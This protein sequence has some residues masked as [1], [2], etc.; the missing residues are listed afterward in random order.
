MTFQICFLFATAMKG[1][2][3][4]GPVSVSC[5]CKMKRN[6]SKKGSSGNRAFVDSKFLYTEG[7]FFNFLVL[8]TYFTI[9][10]IKGFSF[11][12][13]QNASLSYRPHTE[14]L[15]ASITNAYM[16]TFLTFWDHVVRFLTFSQPSSINGEQL[17]AELFVDKDTR[18][19]LLSLRQ[20]LC[21]PQFKE[22][23]NFKNS[24][25]NQHLQPREKGR[26]AVCAQTK[27]DLQPEYTV[28]AAF[29]GHT[30]C[31]TAKTVMCSL[32]EQH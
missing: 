2:A 9:L 20:N 29:Q 26:K 25:T 30:H 8:E 5:L 16:V 6:S 24:R 11:T 27:D 14:T 21:T 12:W 19:Y 1:C 4:W 31:F 3:Q 7:H 32:E 13:K 22:L 15:H 18:I 10:P 17:K 23:Q 28:V